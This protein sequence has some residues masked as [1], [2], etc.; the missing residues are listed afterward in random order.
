MNWPQTLRTYEYGWWGLV[1]F[2]LALFLFFGLTYL[3]PMRRREWRS[4]GAYAAFIVALYTE[5]Y[6]FP[7]TI[8]LLGAALG[9]F[10][11]ANPFAQAATSGPASS[12][13]ATAPGSSWAWV[14][15]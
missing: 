14:G 15:S 1:V 11:F 9:R 10:P 2:H 12:W 3:R 4:L 6:G 13:M 5:M 7:L 8:Y